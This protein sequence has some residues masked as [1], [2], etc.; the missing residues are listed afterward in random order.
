MDSLRWVLLIIGIAIVA[1]V[2]AFTLWQKQRSRASTQELRDWPDDRA[3]DEVDYDDL[4]SLEQ[5]QAARAQHA[6]EGASLPPLE[7]DVVEEIRAADVE[8]DARRDEES[9]L[10]PADDEPAAEADASPYA[11]GLK[12]HFQ[13]EASSSPS[14]PEEQTPQ[15]ESE[16]DRPEPQLGT[17][18]GVEAMADDERQSPQLSAS[19]VDAQR[20]EPSLGETDSSTPIDSAQTQSSEP[21]S[22]PQPE[23]SRGAQAASEDEKA[24]AA[25]EPP[26]Q[27]ALFADEPATAPPKV[28]APKKRREKPLSTE[29]EKPSVQQTSAEEEAA[30]VARA[31]RQRVEEAARLQAEQNAAKADSPTSSAPSSSTASATSESDKKPVEAVSSGTQGQTKQRRADRATETSKTKEEVVVLYLKAKDSIGL[32]GPEIVRCLEAMG[33]KH[34][35]MDIY[36]Y[37]SAGQRIVSVANIEKPGT[38]DPDNM[39]GMTTPGLALFLQLR[40]ESDFEFSEQVL[41]KS[42]KYMAS[43]LKATVL[44]GQRKPLD[45]KGEQALRLRIRTIQSD[46]QGASTR[47]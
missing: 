44:D 28:P 24:S 27:A 4:P 17:T 22:A 9:W 43:Q 39:T 18:T 16:A 29:R 32:Y 41:V 26:Q 1:A 3:G 10:P 38:F 33:F 12:R 35:D 5:L 8:R 37:Q 34:G 36:H 31:A 42:A 47:S 20:P 15:A 23:P 40:P 19:E 6:A 45:A 46:F 2:A 25:T 30:M 11:E 21:R 7:R 13:S 14:E